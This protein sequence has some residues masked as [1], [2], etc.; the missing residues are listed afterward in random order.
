MQ[1][2]SQS[3]DGWCNEQPDQKYRFLFFFI[4]NGQNI[5]QNNGIN[6]GR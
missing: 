4:H 3:V 2:A 1:Q 5:Y 6:Q